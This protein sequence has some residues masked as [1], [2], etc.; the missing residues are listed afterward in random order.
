MLFWGA[1]AHGSI[2]IYRLFVHE[3]PPM[4]SE[5]MGILM[6]QTLAF[7]TVFLDDHPDFVF[8]RWVIAATTAPIITAN[9]LDRIFKTKESEK[10]DNVKK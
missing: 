10:I 1:A 3:M 6:N 7:R 8:W 2:F 5:N 9:L 4:D